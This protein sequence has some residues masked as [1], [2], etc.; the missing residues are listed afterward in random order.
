MSDPYRVRPATADDIDALVEQRLAMFTDMGVDVDAGALVAAYRAWLAANVPSGTY[1]AWV[2]ETD[3]G[4]IVGGGG[5]IVMPWPPGPRYPGT[6]L[7][8]VFNVYTA[9]AHRRRGL[10]KRIMEAIH[11]WCRREGVTSTA[12]NA[13]NEG[14]PLYEALG[15]QLSPRP[16][17]FLS[18]ARYN[19]PAQASTGPTS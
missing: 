1:R 6:R 17:M 18:I 14:R 13:S 4:D 10:A 9:H 3:A 19:P 5:I 8:F 16:M 11:A 15:Y 7:A 12:L 2:V